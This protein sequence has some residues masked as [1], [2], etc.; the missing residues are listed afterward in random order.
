MN[1]TLPTVGPVSSGGTAGP[2]WATNLNTALEVIDS[3]DHSTGKGKRI[4]V[5][6]LSINADLDFQNKKL[7]NLQLVGITST[8][9]SLASAQNKNS[10]Y[11]KD[12]ELYWITSAGVNVQ[13][14]S[15]TGLNQTGVGGIGGD[16]T[17]SDA[18]V[19]YSD[20]SKTYSFKQDSS[21]TGNI[22]CGAVAIYE[23]VA[24]GK[25]SKFQQATSAPSNLT[26]TLPT[27]QPASVS[28][29]LISSISGEMS[30]TTIATT[31][32]TDSAVTTAKIADSNV[33]TAKIADS[34][35][36]TAKIADS[37]VTTAKLAANAVTL[38]KT[39]APGFAVSSDISSLVSSTSYTDIASVS[40]TLIGGRP[41]ELWLN[42]VTSNN[43]GYV[44]VV[45]ADADNA[46]ARLQFTKSDNTHL[47]GSVIVQLRAQISSTTTDPQLGIPPGAIRA[48]V[49]LD[50][51]AYPSAG[52]VT[53]KLRGVVFS[54][55]TELATEQCVLIA[56]EL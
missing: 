4:P 53:I 3:H 25:F 36:T 50:G 31:M 29:P 24:S 18:S 12:G 48:V 34:N 56:R 15:G 46:S 11:V 16:Y 51:L 43:S 26:Y 10:I 42:P 41:I 44:S 32:I 7:S 23:N 27:A 38:T 52:T 1:L 39:A 6:G 28:L 37:N 20:T 13:L 45:K 40:I 35:V 9:S 21:K 33:T 30:F 5:A 47:C 17:T 8:A 22:S 14:T 19:A 54:S 49:N 2:D 55:G